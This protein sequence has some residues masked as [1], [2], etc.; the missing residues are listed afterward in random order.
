MPP[1]RTCASCKQVHATDD[2]FEF[3]CDCD[4]WQGVCLACVTRDAESQ[5]AED[6]ARALLGRDHAV[7][8]RLNRGESP[9]RFGSTFLRSLREGRQRPPP[10]LEF[11][12]GANREEPA[13]M[14]FW[15]G[16]GLVIAL[17]AIVYLTFF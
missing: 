5:D 16:A 10:G 2:P 8:F 11:V 6:Y 7:H 17:L 12:M 3:I 15:D 1:P 14:S 13:P 9:A 4:K